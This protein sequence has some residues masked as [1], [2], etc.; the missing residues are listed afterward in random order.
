MES[1]VLNLQSKKQITTYMKD[2]HFMAYE[3]GIFQEMIAAIEAKDQIQLDW[4]RSFGDS[5][6]TITMNV[7]A[8]RKGLEFGFTEI[9][10]DKYGWFTRPVFLDR[11]ELTFGDTSRYGNHSLIYLGRGENHVWTYGMNYSYGVAGGC[12]GLSVYGKQ[13]KSRQDALSFALNELKTMMTKKI[14]ST[15]TTNDKQPVILATLRDIEKLLFG[16]VQLT[17]F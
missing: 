16:L 14:G 11:E 3:K 1:L 17:L 6:R 5:F 4:F 2:N 12:Y 13:F 10:F 15:D 8:H 7:H 9:S